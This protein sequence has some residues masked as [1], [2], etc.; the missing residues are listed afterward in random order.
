MTGKEHAC[1]MAHVCVSKDNLWESFISFFHLGPRNPTV[2]FSL[3]S[4][5]LGSLR[6][7]PSLSPQLRVQAHITGPPF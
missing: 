5:C 4:K 2:A 7:V 3:C 1:A 6:H